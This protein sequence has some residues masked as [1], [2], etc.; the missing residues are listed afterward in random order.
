MTRAIETTTV[1]LSLPDATRTQDNFQVAAYLAQPQE[2]GSYPGIVVLQEIFGV[3]VHIREVTERIA[4]EGYVAIA[5]ALFQ[6]QAPGFETGYTPQ[7]IET[8]RGYAMQTKASELL[9]DIQSAI[10]YLKSLPQVK[11]DGFGCIGFCFGGHVA[12]LAATLS[13]IK[14]AA[15]F[16]G[17]GIT[18]RTFGG[19]APT[20]TRTPEIKG[21]L[22]AFFGTEDGSISA[23]QIDEIEAGLEKYNIPHRVFRYDGADHGFFCNHRASYNPRA[24]TDAWQQ[25]QQ[26]FGQ[27]I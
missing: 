23:E 14:A 6:R 1:K 10:D 9:S 25:V 7:D 13:D 2:S 24:A 4:Q 3:N 11:K 18:T 22:Y 27:L 19:G 21:T 5:P 16:Y 8:G 26:L 20:V 15:C 12:Y 17:A